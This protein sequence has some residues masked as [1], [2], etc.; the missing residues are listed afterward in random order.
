[1]EQKR[2][3]RRNR[4]KRSKRQRELQLR[5]QLL[6]VV[7]V[8]LTIVSVAVIRSGR[9]RAE[10]EAAEAAAQAERIEAFRKASETPA[11]VTETPKP[12]TAIEIRM[13]GDV[14]LQEDVCSSCL[15]NGTY[16]FDGLFE[17]IS[18]GIQEADLAIA[19]QETILGG[20][21]LGITGWPQF[22]S[23]YEEADALAAAGF[24][25]VLHGNN[26]A[27]D[28]GTEGVTNCLN[29]WNTAHPEMAV[30]GIHGDAQSA[31]DIYVYEKGGFR[32]AVLNYT[33][34]TNL[35]EELL[36]DEN[37]AYYLE[38]LDEEQVT[39]DISRA[40]E[41]SDFVIVCPHWG[42]ED[43]L[44]VST[45]QQYWCE[46]FLNQGVDL[47]LGTHPHVIQPVE[48]M[49]DEDGHQMLVYYS[50]GNYVSNQKHAAAMVGAMADITIRKDTEGVH[51]DDYN[52]IP[53]VTHEGQEP[54][55][56][57][58]YPLEEYTNT[59]A[60]SNGILADDSSF[61]LHYCQE[62]C[63]EVFGELYQ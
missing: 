27:L 57:T 34:G 44:D 46:L 41:I 45:E 47:V 61:S 1:M 18:P 56:F 42:T 36:Q 21:S 50:L 60:S 38:L 25:V 24:Q 37:T 52:V 40:K 31:E 58:V 35:C 29:Y 53:L 48:M 14:I 7:A 9:I 17:H 30:L 20:S 6:A 33:Y 3:Y 62:L 12:G 5:L 32:V 63:R 55:T 49:V 4:K 8:A 51:I 2:R 15:Q 22:N 19:N 23:P 59:L 10:Q 43:V 54:Q 11:P 26:H 39:A 28:Y 16:Q 13:I